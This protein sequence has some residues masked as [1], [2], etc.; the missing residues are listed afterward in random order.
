MKSSR[1]LVF[2]IDDNKEPCQKAMGMSDDE[3]NAC[4]R[5]SWCH[6]TPDVDWDKVVDKLQVACDT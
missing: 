2:L 4:L 6:L 3:A 1:E 5:F